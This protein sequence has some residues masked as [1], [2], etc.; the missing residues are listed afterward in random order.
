[1]ARSESRG[2]LVTCSV[3]FFFFF[4]YLIEGMNGRRLHLWIG[5]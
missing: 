5:F 3:F 2:F 1:M 4:S